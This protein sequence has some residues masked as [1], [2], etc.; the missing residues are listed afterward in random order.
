MTAV[1][2][3]VQEEPTTSID[4]PDNVDEPELLYAD[5]TLLIAKG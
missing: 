2:A 5:D 1:I 3:D 4:K